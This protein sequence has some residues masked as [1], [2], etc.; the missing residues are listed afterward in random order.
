MVDGVGR[1]LRKVLE[2]STIQDAIASLSKKCNGTGTPDFFGLRLGDYLDGINL[3]AIPA[4]N[5]GAA[6]QAWNNTYKNNRIVL[7]GFNTYK[8]YG[9][10][11]VTKNHLL[12]TFRNIPLQYRMNP[13]NDNTGGYIA[14]DMRAF[15]EGI[16]G[17]GTGDKDGV[18][19]AAFLNALNAQLG[20]GHLLTIRKAHSNKSSQA[21]GNY[22]VFLPS[23]LEVF[24]YPTYGDEGVY[25]PALTSPVV[26]ARAGWNTNVQFPIYSRSGVYR[27]KRY[28]GSRMWWW[29]QTPCSASAAY[30]C[31]VGHDGSASHATASAVGGVA[32][33][34]VRC[35]TVGRLRPMHPTQKEKTSC[36]ASREY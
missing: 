33:D 6:G 29:E 19:T 25:M 18:T 5:G 4:E 1:D 30:F 8:G 15:L 3:S 35:Y 23:E 2:A 20:T 32:P 16:N 11:E 9:D 7:S 10:T 34:S 14:S 13:A 12:F 27:I 24:G 26:A 22:T 31:L 28:N 21:W 36:G 17:D